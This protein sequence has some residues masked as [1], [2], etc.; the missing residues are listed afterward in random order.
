MSKYFHRAFCIYAAA[1]AAVPLS[2]YGED[3]PVAANSQPGL[4]EATHSQTPSAPYGHHHTL[5]DPSAA[6]AAVPMHAPHGYVAHN[7]SHPPHGMMETPKQ[8][9]LWEQ[10]SGSIELL[11]HSWQPP[12]TQENL[13]K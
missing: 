8:F 1:A 4:A 2:I 11:T 13:S 7:P 3:V 9:A 10:Y 6:I 12:L 5:A